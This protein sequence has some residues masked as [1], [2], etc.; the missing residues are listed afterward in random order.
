MVECAM[1][2]A[3]QELISSRQRLRGDHHRVSGTSGKKVNSFSI[4]HPS[5]DPLTVYPLARPAPQLRGWLRSS[6]HKLSLPNKSLGR[7][8]R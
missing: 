5:P 4:Y 7:Y 8:V 2:L 1:K 3:Q 6:G